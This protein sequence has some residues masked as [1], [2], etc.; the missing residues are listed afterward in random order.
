[1]E[2][3]ML[4]RGP[5]AMPGGTYG[6]P[7]GESVCHRIDIPVSR[8]PIDFLPN[9]PAEEFSR[10]QRCGHDSAQTFPIDLLA[11]SSWVLWFVGVGLSPVVRDGA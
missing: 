2:G 10:A 3:P 5:S 7:C 8:V 6:F 1:V 9:V 4:L 11:D